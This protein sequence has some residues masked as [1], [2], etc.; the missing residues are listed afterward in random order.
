MRPIQRGFFLS[1]VALTLGLALAVSANAQTFVRS[2]VPQPGV[3]NVTGSDVTPDGA[4]PAMTQQAKEKVAATLAWSAAMNAGDT[5]GAEK[6]V[7]AYTAKWGGPGA[8]SQSTSKNV[9]PSAIVTPLASS[10]SVFLGVV[11]AGQETPYYCGPAAGYEI[12]RYLHG[13]GFTSR[14]DGSALS[15]IGLANANHMRTDINRSTDWS[16]GLYVTGVNRWRGTNYYVQVNAPSAALLTNVFTYSMDVN[17]MPFSGDTVEFAGGAHYNQHPQN[18]TIG[19]WI[20]A[21]GYTSSGAVGYWADSAT[22]SWPW[23]DPTFSYNTS[24][25]STFLQSN[26]IA[27]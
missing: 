14:Y 1:L 20:T 11:Q 19:H 22:T 5:I 23:I 10:T 2:N 13:A 27:Y 3:G 24:S 8:N 15:Q 21:Y 6:A 26:G 18:K 9:A 12:I 25:F 16:S 4:A 7:N 17:G